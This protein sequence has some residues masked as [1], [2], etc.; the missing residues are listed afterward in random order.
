MKKIIAFLFISTLYGNH[1]FTQTSPITIRPSTTKHGP[2]K[3]SLLIIGGN[4]GS[5]AS[6]WNKFTELAGGRDKAH[7]VV[8]TAAFGDSAA[9]DVKDVEEVK[10]QTGISD[11][12]L[13]H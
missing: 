13:L 6:I 3:G 9:Y 1:G 12:V 4:V 2:E 5:T 11:V 7:I 8:V 10:R